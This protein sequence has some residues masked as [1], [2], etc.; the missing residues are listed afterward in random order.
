MF[1]PGD[2]PAT[3]VWRQFAVPW[4]DGDIHERLKTLPES[5]L[6]ALATSNPPGTFARFN[7]SPYYPAQVPDLIGIKDRKYIDHTATHQ[8]RGPADVMRYAALVGCCDPADFGSHRFL[9]DNQ[10]R[11]L[12]KIPDDQAFALTQ[13]IFALEPPRNPNL[14]DPRTAAG[15]QVF[16]REGCANCH[17]PPLYTNN[18][19]TPA[20][21]FTPPANHP[22]RQTS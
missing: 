4:V 5:E 2:S 13:Y 12:Y 11:I 6:N 17:T 21:G 22:Q 10:R 8:L 16:E 14:V 9:A 18:K 3:A 20:K 1:F 7:G 15:K 19:L